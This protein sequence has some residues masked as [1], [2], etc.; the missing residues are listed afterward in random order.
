M[1]RTPPNSPS[2]RA[3]GI[4]CQ[5][6]RRRAACARCATACRPLPHFPAPHPQTA[7]ALPNKSKPGLPNRDATGAPILMLWRS[8]P[9]ACASLST[10][11]RPPA[12]SCTL[13]THP[14]CPSPRPF[15]LRT[16]WRQ[17]RPPCPPS[18]TWPSA[19]ALAPVRPQPRGSAHSPSAPCIQRRLPA[20]LAA[21]LV[22]NPLPWPRLAGGGCRAPSSAPLLPESS[23]PLAPLCCAP[24][25]P[26]PPPSRLSLPSGS[27]RTGPPVLAPRA[28]YY[29]AL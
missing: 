24:R 26:P 18:P 13:P 23:P 19:C 27:I 20:L 4:P 29:P 8:A 5:P 17:T 21:R 16:T 14:S 22:H 1:P 9:A 6:G 7:E 2:P 15:I 11:A 25:L 12:F 3:S 28:S 10:H